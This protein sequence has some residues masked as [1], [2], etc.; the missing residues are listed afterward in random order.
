MVGPWRLERQTST[1]SRRRPKS[2]LPFRFST[3][4]GLGSVAKAQMLPGTSHAR[5]WPA[6][7]AE[8]ETP[9]KTQPV[10]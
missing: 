7:A 5:C 10:Q 8:E 3:L 9:A 6:T 2:T 1:M 4:G